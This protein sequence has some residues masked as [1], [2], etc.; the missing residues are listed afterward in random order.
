[1]SN[2]ILMKILDKILKNNINDK[3]DHIYISINL[4]YVNINFFL[5][6]LVFIPDSTLILS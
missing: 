4:S 2:S 6:S 5:T 3:L 1:M